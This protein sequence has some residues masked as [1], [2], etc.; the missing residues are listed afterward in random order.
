LLLDPARTTHT[1]NKTPT[2]VAGIIAAARDAV[3]GVAGIAPR[4]LIMP[5][6]VADCGAS[7]AIYASAVLRAFD[8]A[9]TNGAHIISCSFGRAYPYKFQPYGYAPPYEDQN[10]Q[11]EAYRRALAPLR[12]AGVLLVAAAGAGGRGASRPV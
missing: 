2:S 5:L 10:S 11:T 7:S 8:Y 6:K 3:R 1:H 9:L 12:A 4:V